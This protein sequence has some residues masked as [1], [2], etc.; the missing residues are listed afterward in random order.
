MNWFAIAVVAVV[1]SAPVPAPPV[2]VGGDYAITFRTPPHLTICR[3]PADWAGSNHGTVVF[4]EPPRT[5]GG[6]GFPS[7]SRQFSGDPRRIEVFYAYWDAD[8]SPGLMTCRHTF[9]RAILFG[10]SRPICREMEGERERLSVSGRYTADTSA[11]ADVALVTSAQRLQRDLKTFRA[12]AGSVKPC[13]FSD[14]KGG[15]Y[16]AGQLCPSSGLFF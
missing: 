6:A 7:S 14:G 12:L 4:L 2:F 10:R 16:D 15:V 1:L 5:C 13:R 8:V 3:L 9:G 11:W